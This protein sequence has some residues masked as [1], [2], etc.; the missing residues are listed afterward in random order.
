MN[1]LSFKQK[2]YLRA[3]Y[4]IPANMLG[5]NKGFFFNYRWL[6]NTVVYGAYAWW[7]LQDVRFL[8]RPIIKASD[9]LWFIFTSW[10]DPIQE[11]LEELNNE[12]YEGIPADDD[13]GEEDG[14]E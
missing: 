8:C 9:K 12:Y 3:I 5:F 6:E 1:E 10:F 2:N 4:E 7:A 11:F 13:N 14:T